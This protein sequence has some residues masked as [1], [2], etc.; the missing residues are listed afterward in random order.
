[1]RTAMLA[2]CEAQLETHAADLQAKDNTIAGEHISNVVY[3]YS[4]GS[5]LCRKIDLCFCK[6]ILRCNYTFPI[7]KLSCFA[8]KS[9]PH[10]RRLYK[11]INFYRDHRASD[12]AAKFPRSQ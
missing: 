6:S 12:L 7:F 11:I 3:L 4:L 2:T 10:L 9:L 5:S 1:M 8:L